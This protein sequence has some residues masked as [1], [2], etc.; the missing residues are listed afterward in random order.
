MPSVAVLTLKSPPVT[1]LGAIGS[2]VL[3]GRKRIV[4]TY[5]VE[6]ALMIGPVMVAPCDEVM[7]GEWQVTSQHTSAIAQARA[8]APIAAN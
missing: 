1:M 5:G 6:S 3:S 8:P 7:S 4:P 2:G